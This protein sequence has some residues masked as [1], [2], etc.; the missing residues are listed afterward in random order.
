MRGGGVDEVEGGDAADLVGE[1]LEAAG[2]WPA[3][4]KRSDAIYSLFC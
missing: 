4:V 2:W 3:K 1:V